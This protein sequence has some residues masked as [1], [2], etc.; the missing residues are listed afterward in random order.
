MPQGEA[1]EQG[2]GDHADERRGGAQAE[3]ERGDRRARGRASISR[4]E[5][6]GRGMR[7]RAVIAQI[8]VSG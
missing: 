2:A 5:W 1:D 6:I 3:R 4:A 8:I 7:R